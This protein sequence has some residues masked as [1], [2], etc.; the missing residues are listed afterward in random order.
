MRPEE[1][2]EASAEDLMNELSS[3]GEG[4]TSP[5]AESRLNERGPNE[6]AEKKVNPIV[7][8][9]A[10]FWGPIPWMIEVAAF[11][12]A[13]LGR[14][15]DFAIISLLLL[16]NGIVGFWQENKADRAIE[17]L[18]KRLAPTARVRRDGEWI[19]LPARVLVPG[20]VVR[21]RL[22][23]IVP[24]DVKLF[25]GDFLQVDESALTGQSLPVEKKP[26]D[27]A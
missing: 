11:L 13:V 7:K 12:S 3:S 14:W 20:D 2:A 22:G 10:Y 26:S 5:E 1:A 18:K 25:G 4:L 24:A 6:I 21:V 23:E 16:M 15:D 27:V 17:L 9:L 19:E 8:F